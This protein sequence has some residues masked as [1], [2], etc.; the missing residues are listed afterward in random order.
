[1]AQQH[2]K[3]LLAV[4]QYLRETVRSDAVAA[5][6][7]MELKVPLHC[8]QRL[9]EGSVDPNVSVRKSCSAPSLISFDHTVCFGG[10]G[11][12]E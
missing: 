11:L 2:A 7:A 5:V 6:E 8:I 4:A 9:L 3:G 12:A 1:M 10:T